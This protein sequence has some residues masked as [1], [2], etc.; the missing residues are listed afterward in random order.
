MPEAIDL[1][2][3]AGVLILYCQ[4]LLALFSAFLLFCRLLPLVYDDDFCPTVNRF[5][6]TSR[7]ILVFLLTALAYG[8]VEERTFAI[9]SA[10]LT[11]PGLVLYRTILPLQNVFLRRLFEPVNLLLLAA[12]F[13]YAR[14]SRVIVFSQKSSNFAAL[15]LLL[16]ASHLALDLFYL[17]LLFPVTAPRWAVV[18]DAC[19]GLGWSICLFMS[20]VHALG[21]PNSAGFGMSR[22]TVYGSFLLLLVSSF[23]AMVVG[24]LGT[25]VERSAPVLAGAHYYSWF[26]ENWKGGYSGEFVSGGRLPAAGEYSSSDPQTHLRHLHEAKAAGLNFFIFDWWAKRRSVRRNVLSFVRQLTEFSDFNFCLQY[27]S[28]DLR[29]PWEDFGPGENTHILYLTPERIERLKAHMLYLAE[30]Y[31]GHTNYLRIHGRPVIFMYATRHLVGPVKQ[32]LEQVRQHVLEKTGHEI[33]IVGD[34]VFS[35]VLSFSP[36]KGI[37]MLPNGVP[38]WSRLSAFD[39]VTAYNPYDPQLSADYY[40]DGGV[41]FLEAT[42]RLYRRYSYIAASMGVDFIPTV[43][44]GYNDRGVRP[45]NEHPVLARRQEGDVESFFFQ[46]LSRWVKPYINGGSI[47]A[48]VVTSWNEWNEGTQIEPEVNS[49]ELIPPAV[50][51]YSGGEVIVADG[52]TA[53]DDLRKFMKSICAGFDVGSNVRCEF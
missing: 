53:Y 30:N 20:A 19:L 14:T 35:H 29:E 43:I 46:A 38:D 45:G 34:E 47:R 39:A 37:Y 50:F 8:A 44:P 7:V 48:F 6:V 41:H 27:E 33:Y 32:A 52:A 4:G 42:K 36:R 21:R 5:W 1:L 23:A 11:D 2:Q 15:C 12:F 51:D 24:R 31:M 17:L 16:F 22:T 40:A 9:L 26:P 13:L 25:D 49:Q 18:L 3:R 10:D 28:F